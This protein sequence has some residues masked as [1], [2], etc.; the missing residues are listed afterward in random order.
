MHKQAVVPIVGQRWLDLDD[1]RVSRV[2]KI[3]FVTDWFVHA[4]RG[5]NLIHTM[6][7]RD[8]MRPQGSTRGYVLV[9]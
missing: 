7:A 5:P 6:I 8:R 4:N 2:F 3:D 9:G 1:R